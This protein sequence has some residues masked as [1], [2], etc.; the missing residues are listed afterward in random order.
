M[1]AE[2]QYDQEY[3][4]D[5]YIA[6]EDEKVFDNGSIELYR[7]VLNGCV[8]NGTVNN[9]VKDYILKEYEGLKFIVKTR[10]E[11]LNFAESLQNQFDQWRASP[12]REETLKSLVHNR[13]RRYLVVLMITGALQFGL[14]AYVDKYDNIPGLGTPPDQLSNRLYYSGAGTLTGTIILSLCLPTVP[15]GGGYTLSCLKNRLSRNL[16]KEYV[17]SIFSSKHLLRIRDDKEFKGFLN[18]EAGKIE[19]LENIVTSYFLG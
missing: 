17:Y 11:I 19:G 16:D 15:S 12:E 13:I 10:K 5:V 8:H 1:R 9:F 18:S 2:I 14:G 7:N 6:I 3:E 4:Q